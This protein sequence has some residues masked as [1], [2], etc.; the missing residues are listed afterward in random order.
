MRR[1]I[2]KDILV[3]QWDPKKKFPRKERRIGFPPLDLQHNYFGDWLQCF[4]ESKKITVRSLAIRSKCSEKSIKNW[5]KGRNRPSMDTMIRII[6]I[7]AMSSG[8]Q[9][10]EVF[11]S[12]AQYRAVYRWQK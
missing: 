1:S 7:L 9:R 3:T 8:M 2:R 6:Q 11:E 5:L 4:L 12:L 10:S